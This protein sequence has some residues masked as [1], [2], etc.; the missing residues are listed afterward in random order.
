MRSKLLSA[1]F[2]SLATTTSA[3]FLALVLALPAAPASAATITY[4]DPNCADFVLSGPAG[5]RTL[6]C[7]KLAC[8]AT[9]TPGAPGINDAVTL[10]VACTPSATQW[11][12][13]LLGGDAGCPTTFSTSNQTAL[14][15]PGQPR[16]CIYRATSSSGQLSGIAD[17]T[18]SWTNVPP[19]PPTGCSITRTPSSGNLPSAGGAISVAGAC[20]GGGA[21]TSWAWQKNGVAWQTGQNQTDTLPAN[22][23]ASALT[24]TYTLTAC[25]GP[26]C[27]GPVQTTFSVA[28]VAA[29]YCASTT[30][31][32]SG[33]QSGELPYAQGAALYTINNGGMPSQSGFYATMTVPAN[34]NF[35]TGMKIGQINVVEYQ[36]GAPSVREVTLSTQPC[37]FRPNTDLTGVNAPMRRAYGVPGG[38]ASPQYTLALAGAALGL[39]QLVPGSTYYINLRNYDPTIFIWTCQTTDCNAKIEMN[40]IP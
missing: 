27:A 35:T 17:I 4:S 29:G 24:T 28:G 32:L 26:S 18:V 10:S 31:P 22:T 21:V 34:A 39:P 12:W 36:D 16:S 9:A 19:P 15:A 8:A 6:T 1:K 7:V 38:A 40:I 37:D 3:A 33:V 13:A 25:N 23:G 11:S 20:T 2:L 30:P 5:A 14:A